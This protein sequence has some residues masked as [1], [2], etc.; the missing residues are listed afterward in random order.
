M[1]S[2]AFVDLITDAYVA[3]TKAQTRVTEAEIKGARASQEGGFGWAQA[4]DGSAVTKVGPTKA[5]KALADLR[6]G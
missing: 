4:L 1:N 3:V 2:T 5:A 6:I